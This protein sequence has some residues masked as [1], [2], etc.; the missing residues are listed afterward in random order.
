MPRGDRTGPQGVG[1]MTGRGAGICAGY[2][3]PG[4]MNESFG[5]GFGRGRGAGMGGG[6]GWR[7]RYYATGVPGWGRQ[8][9]RPYAPPVV[10]PKVARDEELLQLKQQAQHIKEA[11][12]DIEQRIGELQQQSEK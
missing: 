8:F 2:D 4:Y 12:Q 6:R 7:H 9:A 1:P 3:V 5:P 11:L 10:N